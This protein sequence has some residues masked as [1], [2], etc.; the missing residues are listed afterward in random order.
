MTVLHCENAEIEDT[1]DIGQAWVVTCAWL[2]VVRRACSLLVYWLG[3]VSSSSIVGDVDLRVMLVPPTSVA[4]SFFVA[5]R[6]AVNETLLTWQKTKLR[7]CEK[8]QHA[9]ICS[10]E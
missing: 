7:N 6:I 9:L 3:C 10:H 1:M 5:Q 2:C 8:T 4:G